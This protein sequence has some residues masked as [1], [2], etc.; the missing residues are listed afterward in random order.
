MNYSVHQSLATS[1]ARS[2]T[3]ERSIK[4]ASSTLLAIAC[5]SLG[6]SLHTQAAERELNVYTYDSFVAGMGP[7]PD[8]QKSV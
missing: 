7:W 3:L 8:H 1:P 5:L 2:K 4:S 6:V